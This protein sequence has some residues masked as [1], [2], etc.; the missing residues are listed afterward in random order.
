MLA[1]KD[2]G[3]I[4]AIAQDATTGKVLMLGYMNIES[5]K[6]TLDE[7]E[8]WFYSRS[9]GALWHKGETS[10][11][12]LRIQSIQQ[13]CDGDALLL[14]VAPDGPTC[15]TGNQTC[16]FTELESVDNVEP[17]A[18]TD[19]SAIES[20]SHDS[21]I[22][23]EL[24]AVI[25]ARRQD[26]DI[27]SSYT[28]R[29]FQLGNQRIAQKVIEEAGEVALAGV[30]GNKEELSEEIGDLL[31]HALVLM[32]ANNIKPETVWKVLRERRH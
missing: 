18:L 24:F 7:K 3:L 20:S 31:Y 21:S 8:A 4:P 30:V 5:I 16:F 10:G 22:L 12:Y 11:N 9:Q 23:E 27:E 2:N 28:A 14:Q 1:L 13:D 15:H 17:K 6:R 26:E 19:E 29:L 25:Q 32:A